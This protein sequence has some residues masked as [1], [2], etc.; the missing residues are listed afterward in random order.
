MAIGFW[1][2]GS[3]ANTVTWKPAGTRKLLAAVAAGIGPLVAGSEFRGAGKFW[4]EVVLTAIAVKTMRAKWERV[5]LY[6]LGSG[7][8]V[9]RAST[10]NPA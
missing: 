4:A 9:D 6:M 10:K 2:S 7:K 8:L 1:T 3:A 5:V